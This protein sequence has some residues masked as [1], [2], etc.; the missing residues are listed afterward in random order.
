LLLAGPRTIGAVTFDV[1]TLVYSAVAV[2]IGVQAMVFGMFARA[3][4]A[5]ERLLPA[6]PRLDREIARF[7]LEYVAIAGGLLA[8]AGLC[9][10]VY[11]VV[12][13][14][15]YSFGALDPKLLLRI[16]IP[17]ALALGVGTQIVFSAF[18]LSLLKLGRR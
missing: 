10:S 16:V 13:W 14:G 15:R 9:G 12:I 17:S 5:G 7:H 11:A 18:F 4:A 2:M 3:F 8:L 6:N 1:H